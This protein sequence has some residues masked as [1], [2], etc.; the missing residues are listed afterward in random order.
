M[1]S[2]RRNDAWLIFLLGLLSVVTPFAV[3][4]YLPAF[5]SIAED[6]GT[7]SS[8]IALSLSSYFIGFALGQILYGPLLD[9]FGR[10]RPLYFGLVLYIAASVGCAMSHNVH[11]LIALRF[12]QAV[13]GCAAQVAALAM[14]R[15]FFPVKQSA[16]I[17][18]LLFLIIGVSPLLAPT[19]GSAL[20]SA[21]GWRW[22]FLI[23]GGYAFVTLVLIFFL[24]PEGHIPDTSI[25]LKPKPIVENFWMILRQPQFITYALAGAF[26]FAGLFG[27]VSGSP[28]LFMDGYHLG[29]KEFGL[30]FAVLVMGFIG[31]NQAN[32]FLLKRFTSQRIFLNALIFQVI[33]GSLLFA[34][35]RMHL[36]GLRGLLVLFFFFLLSIGLTYPNAAALGMAPFSRDAG[37]ASAMLGFLQAGTG[38]LISTGIGVLGASAIVTLLSATALASLIILVVGRTRIVELAETAAG[39]GVPAIH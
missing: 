17:F 27:F 38:S 2:P 24:L 13:G 29:T 30:V 4:M 10:K 37:S 14:V 3:D 12:V 32:V 6:L 21:F 22:I 23:L 34:E 31:G 20:V 36:I 15:D 28:I 1:T 35:T 25:S 26:S 9:R 16:R 7:T 19:V 11:A 39:D 18:S 8:V 33:M 5:S